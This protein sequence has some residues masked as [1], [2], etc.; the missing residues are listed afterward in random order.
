MGSETKKTA[1]VFSV[2]AQKPRLL[3]YVEEALLSLMRNDGTRHV[4]SSHTVRASSEGK[5]GSLDKHRNTG[6]ES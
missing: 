5:L 3:Q 4:E 6:G 1:L 2:Q